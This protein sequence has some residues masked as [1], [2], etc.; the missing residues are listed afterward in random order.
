[1]KYFVVGLLILCFSLQSTAAELDGNE[2]AE[3]G[4]DI[5]LEFQLV[6]RKTLRD[7]Q[8]NYPEIAKEFSEEGF[9][10]YV[11]NVTTLIVN[12]ALELI[13]KGAAQ[14]SVA[15]NITAENII[16]VNRDRWERIYDW[17]VKAGI[18]LHEYL[19][20]MGHESTGNYN[21]SAHYMALIGAPQT[22]DFPVLSL[23][24]KYSHRCNNK[25]TGSFNVTISSLGEFETT[26]L[27]SPHFKEAQFKQFAK[28]VGAEPEG[29]VGVNFRQ[30]IGI[31]PSGVKSYLYQSN[32][33]VLLRPDTQELVCYNLTREQTISFLYKDKSR[34]LATISSR[35]FS[36]SPR[37][38]GKLIVK[39]NLI[40]PFEE[41]DMT[42]KF[43]S[44]DCTWG[45]GK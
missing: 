23:S 22:S 26:I 16:Y 28:Q 30:Q 4:D 6:A 36:I 35:D 24:G 15:V 2:G 41:V 43:D 14:D 31:F 3:G 40:S 27:A 5:G 9:L 7:I 37:S 17:R 33:C 12:D 11:Q 39:L 45:F 32:T 42:M 34:I 13:L 8:T 29:I 18:V 44:P 10:F 1:M 20:F 19:S 25:T 38:A 21:I